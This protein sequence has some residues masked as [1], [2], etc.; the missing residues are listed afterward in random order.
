M[1]KK[2]FW[3]VLI[4][5]LLI[6]GGYIALQIYLRS[7]NRK[8]TS[9]ELRTTEHNAA[10]TAGS[11]NAINTNKTAGVAAED[12]GDSRADDNEDKP[13]S[14]AGKKVSPLDLRPLFI[15]KLQ[16]LVNKSTNGL[17]QLDVGDMKVDVLSSQVSLRDV[18]LRPDAGVLQ[19]LRSAG[20]LPANV[21]TITFEAL[22]I[23]GINLDDALTSKTMDYKIVKLVKPVIRIDRQHSG[24]QKKSG[25]FSQQ[26]L[27]EMEKLAV[28][29]LVIE[30]GLVEVSDKKKGSTK[31]FKNVQ[32]LLKNI[33]LNSST[34]NAEDRFLF[35]KEATMEFHNFTTTM[36]KGLYQFSIKDAFINATAKQVVLKNLRYGSTVNKE[37]FM[38][39]QRHATEMYNLALPSVIINGMDWWPALNGDAIQ[40]DNIQTK[41]GKLN[42]YF[43]RRLP[44]Q[45][46]MGNFPN[47]M[48][49]KSQ[50]GIHIAKLQ[51]RNMDIAYEEFNPVSGQ[52]GTVTLKSTAL[53]VSNLHNNK[54]KDEPVT[55]SGS[56]LLLGSIPLKASFRFNMENAKKGAFSATLSSD[57]FDGQVL[58][59]ITRPLGMLNID[60]GRVEKFSVTMQGH[61][62]GA[63]GTANLL[64]NNLKLSMLEKNKEGK[65]MNDKD[66]ISLLANVFV[67]RNGNPWWLNGKKQTKEASFN[68]DPNSGFM[69]LVWKTAFT[70]ILKTIGAPEKMANNK[71]VQ[72]P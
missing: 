56:S 40:A 50:M 31:T 16:G 8:E 70:G 63:K 35:A 11:K 52:T 19:Q 34:R 72:Q 1:G 36:N 51:V 42:V 15:Q 61:E 53:T 27:K 59:S 69:N 9:E 17:Y 48:L 60:E 29:R 28:N 6:I 38:K 24:K 65:G 10:T 18:S 37:A 55:V 67:I 32:V 62:W 3:V 25:E 41:G 43:D 21:F 71:P 66:L 5:A 12:D 13:D 57:G 23:E 14:L 47:Q 64:Y 68:R 22:G 30:D 26:F 46:K 2:V 58:N 33:L 49:A 44:P 4:P 7:G 39:K 20:E 45:N 54:K